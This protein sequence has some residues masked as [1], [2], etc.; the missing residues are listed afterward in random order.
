MNWFRTDHIF[1]RTIMF[2]SLAYDAIY[3]MD[4]DNFAIALNG[5]INITLSLVA[6]STN[7]SIDHM[8]LVKRKGIIFQNG[9]QNNKCNFPM[10]I[11]VRLS[12]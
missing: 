8:N 10:Y 2:F 12:C 1:T 3:A 6:T 5:C 4:D 9:D 7:P 11:L